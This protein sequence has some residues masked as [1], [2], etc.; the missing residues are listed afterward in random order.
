MRWLFSATA[1]G[2][3]F[4]L[5]GAPVNE[6]AELGVNKI[7]DSNSPALVDLAR[8]RISELIVSAHQEQQ[9]CQV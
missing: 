4:A 7:R 1:Q 2:A 6:L 9:A 5:F 8:Q 3:L